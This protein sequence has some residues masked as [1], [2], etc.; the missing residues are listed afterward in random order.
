M[1]AATARVRQTLPQEEWDKAT[2]VERKH[3]KNKGEGYVRLPR[4][5]A[6]EELRDQNRS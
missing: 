4:A 5:V 3:W 2:W 1:A 6:H